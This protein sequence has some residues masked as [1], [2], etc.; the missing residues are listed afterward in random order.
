MKNYFS[1]FLVVGFLVTGVFFTVV[2][3]FATGFFSVDSAFLV[4]GFLVTAFLT[5]ASSL[6][7]TAFLVGV[8]FLAESTRV[9]DC[10]GVDKTS[11]FNDNG[12]LYHFFCTNARCCSI[13]FFNP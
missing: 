12:L 13:R 10:A 8:D 4:T 3:F 7:A 1:D 11:L 2:V 5:E 6:V 9:I